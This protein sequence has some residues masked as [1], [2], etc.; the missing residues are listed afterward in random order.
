METR[1]INMLSVAAPQQVML[2]VK[3]AEVSKQVIEKL[4]AELS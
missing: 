1:V 2:E 3:V 4:G